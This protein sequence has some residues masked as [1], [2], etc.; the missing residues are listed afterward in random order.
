MPYLCGDKRI[1]KHVRLLRASSVLDNFWRQPSGSMGIHSIRTKFELA[2]ACDCG[3]A[4]IRET[5]VSSGVHED[6]LLDEHRK[7]YTERDGV[8]V[9]TDWLQI[10]VCH[11]VRMEVFQ[12]LSRFYQLTPGGAF[13]NYYFDREE[14]ATHQTNAINVTMLPQIL[15]HVSV[16]H[17][18]R[19]DLERVECDTKTLQ[20]IWVF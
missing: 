15:H 19:H 11:S 20:D 17:P 12:S 5:S 14:V 16:R 9:S 1:G 7:Y 4:N 2:V 3:K 6:I 13:D 18:L 8:N 10:S